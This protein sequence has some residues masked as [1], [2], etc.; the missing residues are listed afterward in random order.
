MKTW[1]Y[2][3]AHPGRCD[4]HRHCGDCATRRGARRGNRRVRAAIRR[5]LRK[6]VGE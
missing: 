1:N 3:T 6:L 4:R 2:D 5:Q